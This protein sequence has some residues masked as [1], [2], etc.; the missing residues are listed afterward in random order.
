MKLNQPPAALGFRHPACLLAT[1]CGVGLLPMAPG[2]WGSLAALPVAWLITLSGGPWALLAASLIA[3]AAGIWASGV[4]AKASGVE[5][6]QTIVI[7]EIAGQWLA[8]VAAPLHPMAYLAAFALFRLCDIVKPW[9]VNWADRNVH[10]GF[11]VMLDDMIA[12]LYALI[13]LQVSLYTI[14]MA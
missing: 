12:G 14:G 11:G 5:D 8:L 10:G 2:T 4:Y 6:A 9:P 13:V 7:D 3:F 1:G